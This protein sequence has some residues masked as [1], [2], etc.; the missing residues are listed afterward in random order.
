MVTMDDRPGLRE[1]KKQQ[2]WGLIAQTAHRLFQEHGFDAVTVADVAREADV[3]RKTVFN[4]FPT[5]EDLVYS[6]LEFFE[7]RLLD[8]IRERKPGESILAAFARFV[9]ES[10][11]L[12]AADDQALA[13]PGSSRRSSVP[14]N[15]SS[16]GTELAPV[17]VGW[18]ARHHGAVGRRRRQG[19]QVLAA[20]AHRGQNRGVGDVCIVV[21]GGLAGLPEASGTVAGHGD[22]TCIVHLLHNIFRYASRRHWAALAKDGGRSTPLRLRRPRWRHWRR[23]P[24][25]GSPPS[26]SCW[27][28]PTRPAPP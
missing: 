12:L 25:P 8:A 7:A 20:R 6:G 22:Q 3:A 9:T 2:T 21:C 10:R 18:R 23:S 1:R 28:P 24:R 11:G 15:S 4:Y 19:R 5:K 14:S 17:T 26:P 13:D 16:W 27:P